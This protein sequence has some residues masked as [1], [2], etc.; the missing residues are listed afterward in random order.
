MIINPDEV[1]QA[2]THPK[3]GTLTWHFKMLNTRDVS[4]VASSAF[5]WDA[6]RVNLPSGRKCI[7]MSTYPVESA[8]NNSWGRSTEYL[9][10]SIEIYSGKYL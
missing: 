8:G 3:Q 6:A 7:A 5:I 2:A 4:W 10:N 1:G 9:K